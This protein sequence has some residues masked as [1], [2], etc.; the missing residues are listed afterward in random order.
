M[1]SAY[2]VLGIPGNSSADD[3]DE[4]FSKAQA[5]Y[6]AEKLAAEPSA[7]DK[8]AEIQA[9]YK[10]L[11]DPESR[12]AHDRKL[13]GQAIP[14]SQRRAAPTVVVTEEKPWYTR[15]LV[16]LSLAVLLVAGAGFYIN[17]KNVAAAKAIA[18]RELQEKK[19]AEAALKLETERIA[20][21]AAEREQRARREEQQDRQF[22]QEGNRAIAVART[23]ETHNRYVE[24][25]NDRNQQMD[26]RREEAERR[27]REQMATRDAQQRAQADKNRLRELC[28]QNYRRYDC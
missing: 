6:S 3:I 12:A 13:S 8:F 22:R 19:V 23:I 5:H 27:S 24:V 10:V 11:R 1:R 20:Q 7:G 16:V 4:A 9:A 2:T 14:A 26:Q 21:E 15:P 17:S 18:E 28:Y 25:Q